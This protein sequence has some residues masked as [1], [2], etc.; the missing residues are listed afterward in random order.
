MDIPADEALLGPI[1]GSVSL[2]LHVASH[3]SHI[4]LSGDL[5]S[6]ITNKRLLGRSADRSCSLP[7]NYLVVMDAL[8]SPLRCRP[9]ALH[10][11]SAA[12]RLGRSKCIQTRDRELDS[13]LLPLLV[14]SF[15]KLYK[16]REIIFNWTTHYSSETVNQHGLEDR[17]QA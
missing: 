14:T 16:H 13:S 7:I 6:H 10:S 1:F 3:H 17:W 9:R 8:H 2:Q 12:H 4:I 11:S 5:R 15:L